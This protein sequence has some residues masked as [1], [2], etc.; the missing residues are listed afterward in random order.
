MDKLQKSID[1]MIKLPRLQNSSNNRTDGLSKNSRKIRTSGKGGISNNIISSAQKR[2][3]DA[4]KNL[5]Q[6]N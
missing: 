1:V 2:K 6:R 3:H 5:K 4:I